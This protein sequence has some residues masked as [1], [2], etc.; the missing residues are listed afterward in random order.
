MH[1][2]DEIIEAIKNEADYL[3][4]S[5]T[6]EIIKNPYVL[7]KQSLLT[8]KWVSE[9]DDIEL[10]LVSMYGKSRKA[11]DL[12]VRVINEPRKILP[13]YYE[14]ETKKSCDKFMHLLSIYSKMYDDSKIQDDNTDK[15]D[16]MDKEETSDEDDLLC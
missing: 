2:W 10:F 3:N 13:E 4:L 14:S 8:Q 5:N 6:I 9:A 16:N 11:R 12:A 7:K 15:D 1:T